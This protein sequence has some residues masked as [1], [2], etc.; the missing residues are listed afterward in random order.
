MFISL[1]IRILIRLTRRIF[2]ISL[3]IQYILISANVDRIE[4]KR[5]AQT[6]R[7]S[8]PRI[9]RKKQ[10]PTRYWKKEIVTVFDCLFHPVR[11]L[12]SVHDRLVPA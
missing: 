7:A 6:Y 4:E 12:R 2:L 11:A 5:K 3:N 10:P 1:R 8:L 9:N